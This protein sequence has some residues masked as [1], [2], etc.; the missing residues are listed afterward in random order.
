M[1]NIQI[2]YVFKPTGY[3]KTLV[4][5]T[6]EERGSRI[7]YESVDAMGEFSKWYKEQNIFRDKKE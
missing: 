2:N 6:D 1:F 4:Q 3:D 7:K 5:V